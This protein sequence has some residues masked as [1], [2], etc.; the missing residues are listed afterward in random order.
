MQHNGTVL[1][2]QEC[3]RC[4]KGPLMNPFGVR[5]CTSEHLVCNSLADTGHL[6]VSLFA[7]TVKVKPD[8]HGS[9]L[10]SVHILTVCVL[11]P[12]FT[13]DF[14]LSSLP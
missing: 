11:C 4:S 3:I 10:P 9:Y 2:H 7:V 6:T 1:G 5:K 8:L 14:I 12:N 13:P